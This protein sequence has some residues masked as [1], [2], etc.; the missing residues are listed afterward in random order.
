MPFTVNGIGTGL[1]AASKRRKVDGHTQFDAIEALL[2]FYLP[3]APYKTIHVVSEQGSQYRSLPLRM[4]SR[5]VTKAFLNRWGN[6]LA[7]FG[8]LLFVVMTYAAATMQRPFTTGDAIFLAVTG[9]AGA[10][11]HR[12]QTA[13]VAN[14]QARP[15]R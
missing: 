4:S 12:L 13:V 2:V 3:V 14:G 15:A 9:A 11:R 5:I 6:I 8:S 7:I 10:G 1:V